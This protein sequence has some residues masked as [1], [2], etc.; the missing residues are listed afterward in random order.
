MTQSAAIV[1][2]EQDSAKAGAHMGAELL[3]AFR[4]E[5]PDAVILFASSRHDQVALLRAL[6]DACRPGALVGSSSAGEFSNES[7]GVGQTCALG[8]RSADMRFRA[9][10]GR[11]LSA[12]PAAAAAQVV[13]GLHGM[14]ELAFPYKAALLMTD[15]LAGF[16][17]DLV[18]QL[19]RRTGG[20]YQFFGGGA[21]DDARFEQTHVF[22]GLEPVR[23]A[24]VGLEILS[25]RPLG[26]GV[27]H[28]WVPAGPPLRVTAAEGLEIVS[29]NGFPAVEAYE[30]HAARTGQHFD[31]VSPVPFFLHNILGI[32]EGDELYRLRVPLAITPEG[33]VRC[34]AEVPQGSTVRIMSSSAETAIEAASRAARA[35]R[36][37]LRGAKPAAALF[38]DCVATRLRLGSTFGAEL[39][40]VHEA[41][42]RAT[43]IG[44]NTYGQIARADGQ[45][46][47]FH[48]CT[49]VVCVLPE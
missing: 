11:D 23:N 20:T 38:F 48:N 44:C 27:G 3:R 37:N 16:A 26:I 30:E 39:G 24:V 12:D 36:R 6:H 46:G 18:E 28:G 49:A 32:D 42:E 43:L 15:A 35:A 45:F 10:I 33:A 8:L 34:A 29:L 47:G 5:A 40:S 13:A 17:D 22:F 41:L 4:G 31:R 7:S 25:R 2:H 21:G 19:T 1:S 14:N 9:T